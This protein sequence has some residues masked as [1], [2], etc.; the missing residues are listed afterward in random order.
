MNTKRIRTHP[1]SRRTLAMVLAGV[2]MTGALGVAVAQSGAA[3]PGS[4]VTLTQ[5]TNDAA[6]LAYNRE[7][8][9][10]AR[11]LYQALAEHYDGAAPFA[12]ITRSEQMHWSAVGALLTTHGITDPSAGL[13]AGSYADPAIQALY[14]G[15]LQRG[16]TSLDAAYQVGVELEK[17]DIADL[18]SAIARTTLAD[19]RQV[20]TNLRTASERHLA[21]FQAAASGQTPLPG[22]GQGAGQG[23]GAGERAGMGRHEGGAGPMRQGWADA[24]SSTTPGRGAGMTGVRPTDCPNT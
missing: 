23:M 24:E 21:A 17:R 3:A 6:L 13:A 16:L 1:T 2:T 4:G 20:L 12:M 10:M 14:D 8:E 18:D 9:R 7:E 19:A 11:D 22:A 5:A 15:W